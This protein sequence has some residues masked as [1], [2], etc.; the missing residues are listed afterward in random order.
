VVSSAV[1]VHRYWQYEAWYYDFG[2]FYQAISSVAQLKEPIIDHFVFTDK[3]ILGDHFHPIIFLASPFVA[4]FRTG[5]TILIFQALFVTLSGLFVYMISKH[6]QKNVFEAVSILTIYLSFIG[7]HNAL[8]S[9]FHAITLLPLPLSIFFYGMVTKKTSWYFLG[10]IGVLIT[11]ESTFVIPAWFSLIVIMKN[12]GLWR[13]IGVF[14]LILSITYG[15]F[16]LKVVFPLINGV[17]YYYTQSDSADLFNFKRLLNETKIKTIFDT[18]ATHGFLPLLAPETLPPILFN[19]WSRFSGLA[20]TRHKLGLHYNAEIAPTLIL[21]VN[22]GWL[23]YKTIQNKL[24]PFIS[25]FQ[26]RIILFL[27]VIA[28]AGLNFKIL[29]SPL[30][31]FTNKAFFDHSNDFAFLDN[32][33]EAI[34]DDGIV[35]AQQNIAAK[36]SDRKVYILREDYETFPQ[37]YIVVDFREEQ[38]P[39]NFFGIIHFDFFK[40]KLLTDKNY[41]LIYNNQ[42]QK[43][44]EKIS[45]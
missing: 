39:N 24:L 5:E 27:L 20:T 12:K 42:D 29:N 30:M 2:I 9:E 34:P 23:R 11:K 4:L 28:I 41:K 16:L 32:L 36:I 1:S 3:N 31:L 33:V 37:K 7:L 17:G 6:Y 43:I 8:I 10:L 25:K 26:T 40:N 15:L 13:K 14:T 35:M 45:Y 21:A 18:L 19:W 38:N 22:I 44:F